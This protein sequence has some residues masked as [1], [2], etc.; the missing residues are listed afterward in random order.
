MACGPLASFA[1]HFHFSYFARLIGLEKGVF[2][3]FFICVFLPLG[4]AVRSSAAKQIEESSL[5]DRLRKANENII[6]LGAK[7]EDNLASCRKSSL[8]I[9][10]L[11]HICVSRLC[12]SLL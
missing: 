3:Y 9:G 6:A 5:K 2:W 11:R 1:Y 8:E 7:I 4:E 12:I 10:M